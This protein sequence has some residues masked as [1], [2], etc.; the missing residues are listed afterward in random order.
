MEINLIH[1]KK[2]IGL[3]ETIFKMLEHSGFRPVVTFLSHLIKKTSVVTN[4]N[5][6]AIFTQ[7]FVRKLSFFD[8]CVHLIDL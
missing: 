8:N 3:D 7:Y 5:V 2:L 4:V 1:K 6:A